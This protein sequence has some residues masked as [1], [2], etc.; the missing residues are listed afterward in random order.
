MS[1]SLETVDHT[2]KGL[3]AE[4]TDDSCTAAFIEIVPRDPTSD[5]SH[6]SEFI[7]RV[8]EVKPDDLQEMKQEPADEYDNGDSHYYV[9]H[10]LA[11]EY[12]TESPSFSIKVSC[13]CK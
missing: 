5:D 1:D 12:K 4:V 7:D 13:V 2:K 3:L 11:D 6:T 10:E 9:K 8:I